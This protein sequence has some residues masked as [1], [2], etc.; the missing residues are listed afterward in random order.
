MKTFTTAFSAALIA[1]AAQADPTLGITKSMPQVTVQTESGPQ[2][3]DRV[4]DPS[5]EITGQWART[6]RQCPEFCIQ[7]MSPAPGVSTIGELELLEMLQDPGSVVV[8]SRTPDWFQ[9]GTI[10][11]AINF[12][13]GPRCRSIDFERTSELPSVVVLSAWPNAILMSEV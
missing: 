4:Q 12:A 8:D 9:G 1:G 13:S 11:G 3:I 5:N 7:A 2:V 10:P 6:S